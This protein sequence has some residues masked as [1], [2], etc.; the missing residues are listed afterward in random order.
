MVHARLA[1]KSL[2]GSAACAC[3]SGGGQLLTIKDT[4]Q[5]YNF[6]RLGFCLEL[7]VVSCHTAQ[8]CAC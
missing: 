6:A 3:M 8:W 4:K 1:G 7:P 2:R 5:P